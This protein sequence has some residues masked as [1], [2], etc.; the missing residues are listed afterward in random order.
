MTNF[1][2]DDHEDDEDYEKII[3]L[4]ETTSPEKPYD[5]A[6][7]KFVSSVTDATNTP[8]TIP[9]DQK[10]NLTII[11]VEQLKQRTEK[12]QKGRC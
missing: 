6:L 4:K 10:R 9:D 5:L 7:K 2:E 1:K 11:S 8:K 3:L 12:G